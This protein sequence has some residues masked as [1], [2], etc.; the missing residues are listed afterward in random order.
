[1]ELSRSKNRAATYSMR[2]GDGAEDLELLL[3]SGRGLLAF[4]A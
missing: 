3:E 4:P 2:V 1:M